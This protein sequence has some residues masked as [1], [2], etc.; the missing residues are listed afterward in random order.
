[1]PM[2]G[3]LKSGSLDMFDNITNTEVI[4]LTDG[5]RLVR[6]INDNEPENGDPR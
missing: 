6:Y 3:C 4:P 1:M 5:T 2:W